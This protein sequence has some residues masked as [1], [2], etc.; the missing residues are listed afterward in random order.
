MFVVQRPNIAGQPP[1]GHRSVVAQFCPTI[2]TTKRG[3][4][5]IWLY[6]ECLL[7]FWMTKIILFKHLPWDY[8][9]GVL[10]RR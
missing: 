10:N 2:Q 8:A 9:W 1:A 7:N 5:R 3:A 4:L 6:L